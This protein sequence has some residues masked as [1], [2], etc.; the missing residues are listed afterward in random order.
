MPIGTTAKVRSIERANSL[1]KLLKTVAEE[2]DIRTKVIF[3][4]GSQ[5]V[6]RG[7][8]PVLEALDVLAVLNCDKHAPQDLREHALVLAAHIIEFSPRFCQ[9]KD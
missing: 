1:K 6:G 7:I 3:S 9:D 5:P 8:G 4:D 2:F